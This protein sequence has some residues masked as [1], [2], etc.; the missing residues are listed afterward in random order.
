MAHRGNPEAKKEG[1]GRTYGT[2]RGLGIRGEAVLC[3]GQSS[4]RVSEVESGPGKQQC[5]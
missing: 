4:T 5:I 3:A 1:A 2:A